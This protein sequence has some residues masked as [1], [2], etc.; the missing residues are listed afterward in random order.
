MTGEEF[1]KLLKIDKTTLSKWENNA[2]PVGE[3]SDRLIR[4]IAFA[5]GCEGSGWNARRP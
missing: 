3:Q 1:S 4:T 5:K 2:D